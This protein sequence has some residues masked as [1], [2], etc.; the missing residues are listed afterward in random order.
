[1]T[2]FFLDKFTGAFK[3]ATLLYKSKVGRKKLIRLEN[4]RRR[5]RI[6]DSNESETSSNSEPNICQTKQPKK[7]FKKFIFCSV[8][9]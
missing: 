4:K 3:L 8:A 1:L 6:L 7:V 9:R 5:Q 2:F